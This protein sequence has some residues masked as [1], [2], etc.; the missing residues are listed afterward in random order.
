MTSLSRRKR[1][2]TPR[3]T[4]RSRT[5]ASLAALGWLAG[6][7]A[8]EPPAPLTPL[9]QS[10]VSTVSEPPPLAPAMKRPAAI[11][12]AVTPL[13]PPAKASVP[14][15]QTLY[16]QK[17]PAPVPAQP[18]TRTTAPARPKPAP[19]ATGVQQVAALQQP[20]GPGDTGPVKLPP[21]V[22]EALKSKKI[23]GPEVI[24]NIKTERQILSEIRREVG[25]N[26]T[27][28]TFPSDLPLD[29]GGYQPLSTEAFAGRTF[30]PAIRKAEPGYVV[31]HRLYF[32]ELNSE[33]YGW[34]VG[35]LQPFISTGYFFYDLA[36]MPYNFATRPCQ[37]Y[38]TSYGKCLPGD[39]VPYILYPQEC[40]V[41][42]GLTEA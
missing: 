26:V 9:D 32:E 6:A 35:P 22:E 41:I 23:P 18:V 17:D 28:A 42:G 11:L 25:D 33:R 4:T 13:L 10:A 36:M 1:P 19:A 40:S 20:F 30:P 31:H 29:K 2:T 12:G 38:D 21:S 3:P 14:Q 34:E 16:Y 39:S 27:F 15:P 24:F 5:I 37:R 8:A 7:T